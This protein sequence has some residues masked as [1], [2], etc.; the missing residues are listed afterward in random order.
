MLTQRA[1]FKVQQ[2]RGNALMQHVTGANHVFSTIP[3]SIES[4]C[5]KLMGKYSKGFAAVVKEVFD[6]IQAHFNSMFKTRDMETETSIAMRNSLR[7]LVPIAQKIL[8][9]PVMHHLEACK[10]TQSC[11]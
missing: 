11:S 8:E 2:L 4:E 1:G 3:A 5:D 9:G 7:E 10:S 6:E